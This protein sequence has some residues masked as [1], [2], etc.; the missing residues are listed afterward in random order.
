MTSAGVIF[1][2]AVGAE[3]LAGEVGLTGVAGV[4]V[5]LVVSIAPGSGVCEVAG[6][7]AARTRAREASWKT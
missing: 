2:P 7:F 5:V 1:T 3:A 6:D 4:A